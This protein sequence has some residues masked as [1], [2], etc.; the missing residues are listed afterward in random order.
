MQDGRT[1]PQIVRVEIS[2]NEPICAATTFDLEQGRQLRICTL[3]DIVAEKLR[4]LLQQT[5]R[6]RERRQDLLDIAVILE[7]GQPLDRDN[8]ATFLIEKARARDV[9]VSRAAFRDPEIARRAS[10]DYD[11]LAAT[12]RVRFIPFDEAWNALIAFVDE[13][14]IPQAN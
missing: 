3:E 13:L 7:A 5:I 4:A 14:D 11:E 9:P 2:N 6:N 12:T 10:A 1:S 8:V